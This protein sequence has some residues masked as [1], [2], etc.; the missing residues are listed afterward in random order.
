MNPEFVTHLMRL[1]VDYPLVS[2]NGFLLGCGMDM[3]VR[4]V[5]LVIRA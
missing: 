1:L 2:G 5:L 4:V 3:T